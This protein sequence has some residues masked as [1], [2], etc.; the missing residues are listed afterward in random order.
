MVCQ[1]PDD[2]DDDDDDDDEPTQVV[3]QGA[4]SACSCVGQLIAFLVYV[5]ATT[6]PILLCVLVLLPL[7]VF[8]FLAAEIHL[9]LADEDGETSW[10]G[11]RGRRRYVAVRM[12]D[13]RTTWLPHYDPLESPRKDRIRPLFDERGTRSPQYI[14]NSVY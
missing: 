2:D 5:N 12:D 11:S 1:L 6:T 13:E 10:S 9:R 8:G 4:L 7:A 3:L 14:A